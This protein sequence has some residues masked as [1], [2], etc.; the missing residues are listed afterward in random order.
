MCA[1]DYFDGLEITQ[2]HGYDW[3]D[4]PDGTRVSSVIDSA[5]RGANS[6]SWYPNNSPT[7]LRK[8]MTFNGSRAFEDETSYIQLKLGD[9]QNYY[10][11][12]LMRD[13]FTKEPIEG[14][15]SAIFD[16]IL[17]D[18]MEDYYLYDSP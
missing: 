3:N 5:S 2:V 1:T 15:K 11:A 18:N 10:L 13:R 9:H 14:G 6:E 12:Y 7:I 8:S 4:R 17:Y 16:L